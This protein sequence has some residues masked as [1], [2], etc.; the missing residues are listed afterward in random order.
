M[1]DK[2]RIRNEQIK[3]RLTKDER[4]KNIDYLEKIA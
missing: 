4:D 1:T 3:I 2:N